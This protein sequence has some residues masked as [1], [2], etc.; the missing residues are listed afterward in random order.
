MTFEEYL[1]FVDDF[2]EIFGPP[3]PK[4]NFDYKDVRF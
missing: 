2:W 1:D 3:P 4:E